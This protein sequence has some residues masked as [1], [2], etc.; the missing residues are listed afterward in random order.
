MKPVNISR[1]AVLG[2]LGGLFV[3]LHLPGCAP[4]WPRVPTGFSSGA[5][6]AARAAPEGSY[7]SA[8]IRIAPDG[9]V[10]LRLGASE[11]GQGVFTALPMIL[12]E[13]LDADWK[14]VSIEMAPAHLEYG[15]PTPYGQTQMTAASESVR[16]Y[17]GPLRAAG[18]FARSALIQAA[19]DL[20]AVLVNDLTTTPGFVTDGG[21]RAASYGELARAAALINSPTVQPLKAPGDFRLVATSPPRA[22][23]PAKTDGSAAFGMDTRKPGM[24]FAA[25]ASSPVFGGRV[26]SVDA[27]SEAQ[28]RAMPGVADVLTFKRFVAVTADSTWRARQ[29]LAALVVNWEPGP[30]AGLDSAAISAQLV[31][32]LDG[33]GRKIE[34]EGDPET[35]F[36]T[37][38]T[39]VEAVYEVPYLNHAPMEPLNCT[40]QVLPDRVDVWV[41]TQAQTFTQKV[42]AKAAGAP[43]S[44]VHVHTT[45][46]GGGFGRRSETDFV[47]QAARI[48]A[49]TYQAVQLVWSREESF[50]H[51]FYRP[52]F[53][54]RLRAGVSA[55]G[56][57]RSWMVDCSGQSILERFVPGVVSSLKVLDR[58]M[59]EGFEEMHYTVP[60][61]S[62]RY[63][64]QDIPIPV[65]FWRSVAHSHNAFFKECFLDEVASA[66]G[67][68]PVALRRALLGKHPRHA[69]VMEKAVEASG[70]GRTDPGRYQGVALH[71]SFGSIVA[72]VAEVSVDE[73]RVRV[74]RVTAAVD[75]GQVIHP[76]TVAAQI[77]GSVAF[78]LSAALGEEITIEGG[79]VAQGNFHEYPI[80]KLAQMPEVEVH[81][82]DSG[83]VE[84]GG[85]GEIGVPPVAPAVCNAIF[86]ATGVRI[87]SLP[88]SKHF[89]V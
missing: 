5:D 72:M 4:L 43:R 73:G 44:K 35:A 39:K 30:N 50:R 79:R 7:L 18:Q 71:E 6:G 83:E 88:V 60:T 37:A 87:R 28:A 19:A 77:E 85:V 12:A 82:V 38:A 45:F 66:A 29:A 17:W 21:E 68:D 11:M 55:E 67:A 61:H 16:A 84:P 3:G 2:G 80:L 25:S 54:C 51:G 49:T 69:A 89:E 24:L 20:W 46:L 14:R 34:K 58:L 56:E 36:S 70:W 86:V 75:C 26:G 59:V 10:T 74:H 81:L 33:K 22:D 48:A 31:A 63:A 64:R 78:G 42:A 65:G 41:P 15:H 27:A 47:D 53:A 57:V 23:I 40:V 8:W 52:A 76:D 62:L 32:G 1:R 13:E 9:A